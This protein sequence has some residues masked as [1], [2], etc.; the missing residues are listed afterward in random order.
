MADIANARGN[1]G[2][3]AEFAVHGKVEQGKFP[4]ARFI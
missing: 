1:K 4:D 3:T 2:A